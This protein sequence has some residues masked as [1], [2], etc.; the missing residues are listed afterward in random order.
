MNL[1]FC[2][3]HRTGKTTLANM[4][5]N[6]KK[7]PFVKTDTS[8]VF[9]KFDLDPALPMKF[10]TRLQIQH[11][12]LDS[13]IKTWE[14][15]PRIFVSDRTPID[16]IAYTLGDILGKTDVDFAAL[17]EYIN[18]CF[19]ITNKFFGKLILVQPGIPLVY[20]SGK[21]ALNLAYI[22]H[23]HFLILGLCHDFRLKSTV[24]CLD[25]DCLNLEARLEVAMNF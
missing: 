14:Q 22:E 25:R 24:L 21:A 9:A 18:L 12:I 4:V 1:G 10:A 3:A 13:A 5:A 23:I 8:A 11:Q 2:G 20:E 19:A 17:D 6:Q 16:M 15:E 7:L